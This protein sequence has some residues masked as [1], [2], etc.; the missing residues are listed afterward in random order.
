MLPSA[1]SGEISAVLRIFHQVQAPLLLSFWV[2]LCLFWFLPAFKLS[3][4]LG[5]FR[6]LGGSPDL[7][8]ITP[9]YCFRKGTGYHGPRCPPFTRFHLRDICG[10][11]SKLNVDVTVH[12]L[13]Y[14]RRVSHIF[15]FLWS[16]CLRLDEICE[17]EG[18]WWSQKYLLP[19]WFVPLLRIHF[20][21]QDCMFSSVSGSYVSHSLF[22]CTG[23]S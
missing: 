15:I 21:R 19:S 11:I 20:S 2:V 12:D 5:R 1:L 14:W 23:N 6:V 4:N 3:Q 10:G 22:I 18:F 16:F 17:R 13:S 7:V 8:L 9:H